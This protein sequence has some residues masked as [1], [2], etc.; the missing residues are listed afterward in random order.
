MCH[1][2]VREGGQQG[3]LEDLEG[4][5]LVEADGQRIAVFNIGRSYYCDREHVPSSG[6]P[7]RRGSGDR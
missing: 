3:R 5:K 2:S 7:S 4:G 6:R 1:G